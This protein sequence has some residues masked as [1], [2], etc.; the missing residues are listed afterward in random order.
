ME[1]SSDAF[2]TMPMLLA[3]LVRLP[4]TES[5][6][7]WM[8]DG[9]MDGSLPGCPSISPVSHLQRRAG[10]PPP[11]QPNNNKP[12]PHN[13]PSPITTNPTPQHHHPPQDLAAQHLRLG[14]ILPH[15]LTRWCEEGALPYHHA[16][17]LLLPAEVRGY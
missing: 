8:G 17:A 9:W 6:D 15:R 13:I 10:S 2:L 4:H 1:L 5:V 7:G 12:H 16:W 14:H 3:F 11:H